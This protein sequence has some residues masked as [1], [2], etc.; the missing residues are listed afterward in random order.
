MYLESDKIQIFPTSNR[1]SA[2]QAQ[3]RLMT[4]SNIINIV[5]RLVDKDSFIINH[6]D[7]SI[8]FN[9]HGYWIHV[10]DIVPVTLS[11][12]QEFPNA[13]SI[14][15]KITI[16]TTQSGTQPEF[17]TINGTDT[18]A[19]GGGQIYTGVEFVTT[20]SSSGDTGTPYYLHLLEK[21]GNTWQVPED[22]KVRFT[23]GAETRSVTID[24]GDLDP[25]Q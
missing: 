4:E 2:Y 17:K 5:N 10:P 7:T 16:N 8:D 13:T 20:K 12:Q 24:D 15:A 1:D 22:S 6:K 9:I 14:Y 19:A 11:I 25:V 23:T 18:E 3:A 21:V